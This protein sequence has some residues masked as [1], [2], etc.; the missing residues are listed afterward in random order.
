MEAMSNGSQKVGGSRAQSPLRV[1]RLH[2]PD[3]LA[4]L[5]ALRVILGLPKQLPEITPDDLLND[6]D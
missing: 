1:E 5:S 2:Q 3:R 6:V 4:M